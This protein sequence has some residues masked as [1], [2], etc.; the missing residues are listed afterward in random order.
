[1]KKSISVLFVSTILTLSCVT[2]LANSISE[3]PVELSMEI[4]STTGPTPSADI[5]SES[6]LGPYSTQTIIGGVPSYT[7]Y[8]GCGPTAVGMVIG[9]WDEH[10]FDDLVDGDASTQTDEVKNMM[11]TQ[12]NWDDYCLPLDSS[13]P[14]LDDKSE[15]PSGDEHSNNC[16]ADF[17]DT[18]QSARSL[19]YGWSWYSDV[20]NGFS[21]YLNWKTPHY[22]YVV[23]NKAGNSLTWSNY[24]AEIDANHP[25]VL[26][27]ELPLFVLRARKEEELLRDYFSDKFDDY[28]KKS[29]FMIPFIG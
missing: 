20:D 17:M 16:V 3:Q 11:S 25:V 4:Y 7:W 19:R 21:G 2:V 26:L 15:P 1:M 5:G 13:G 14:I 6:T 24:C 18:S 23:S 8:R 27:V 22:D 28:R 29:S 12:G 9:Y 10:G